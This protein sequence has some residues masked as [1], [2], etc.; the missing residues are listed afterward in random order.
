MYSINHQFTIDKSH[1][2]DYNKSKKKITEKN[3]LEWMLR[4][5]KNR[6]AKDQRLIAGEEVETEEESSEKKQHEMQIK[7]TRV[8]V[9]DIWT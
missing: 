5:E 9:H 2:F 8:Y 7:N 1:I 6:R 3:M 4:S